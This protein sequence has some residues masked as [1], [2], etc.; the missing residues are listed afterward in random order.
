MN[1]FASNKYPAEA[2]FSLTEKSPDLLSGHVIRLYLSCDSL[3]LYS[4]SIFNLR[5]RYD[6]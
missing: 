4:E 6:S 2:L 3:I 1:L 5:P